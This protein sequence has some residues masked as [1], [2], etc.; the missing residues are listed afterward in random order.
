VR[1]QKEEKQREKKVLVRQEQNHLAQQ[2]RRNKLIKADIKTGVRDSDGKR[3]QVSWLPDC[4]Y[5]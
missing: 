1:R 3:I 5:L 4:I 2:K